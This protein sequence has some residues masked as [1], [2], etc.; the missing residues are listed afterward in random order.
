MAAWHHQLNGRE[1]SK[2]SETVKDRETGHA[3]VHRGHK[4]SYLTEQLN[5]NKKGFPGVSVC[6]VQ[7]SRSVM[8]HSL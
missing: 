4:E 5:N 8:S 1:L 7:L 3:A 2:L 6:S